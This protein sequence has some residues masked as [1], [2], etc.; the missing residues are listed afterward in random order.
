METGVQTCGLPIWKK[1]E[2][3]AKGEKPKAEEGDGV[4]VA[5]PLPP[6][7]PQGARAKGP[8]PPG[9]PPTPP[10][11]GKDKKVETGAKEEKPKAEEGDAVAV[12]RA[13]TSGPPRR[14]GDNG[15]PRPSTTNTPPP[16][17]KDKTVE[18]GAKAEHPKHR[19]GD[20][21]ASPT[22]QHICAQWTTFSY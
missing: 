15:A 16:A 22:D 10:L 2:T 4:A 21:A 11:A 18:S 13:L 5:R 9:P 7:H 19:Y 14:S 3:G 8:P 12:A 17:G 6:G 20:A 1:V